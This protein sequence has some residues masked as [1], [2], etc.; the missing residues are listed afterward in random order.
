MIIKIIKKEKK[1]ELIIIASNIQKSS[2][3]LNQLDIFYAGLFSRL[4]TI[5]SPKKNV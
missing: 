3:N 5:G 4:I 1:N 2:Q